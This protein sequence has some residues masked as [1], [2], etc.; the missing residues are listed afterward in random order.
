MERNGKERG[1]PRGGRPKRKGKGRE[2]KGFGFDKA[3]VGNLRRGSL[4]NVRCFN[5]GTLA[6]GNALVYKVH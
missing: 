1:R 4:L 5:V 6:L 2:G 3:S